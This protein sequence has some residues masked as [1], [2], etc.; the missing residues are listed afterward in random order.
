[1]TPKVS[2]A[3]W[4]EEGLIAKAQLYVEKMES[5]TAD[6]WQF[7]LWSTFVLELVARAA[8][9][10]ISPVLLA[11]AR[12]WRNLTYA[13]GHE[14][15]A[16][17][18][19]PGSIPTSEVVGRLEELVPEVTREISGICRQHL[20]RRNAELH[21]GELIF[22]KLGTSNWLPSFYLALQT[23]I[24]V[25]GKELQDIVSDP[26]SASSMIEAMQD[27]TAKA[28]AQDIE[29]HQKVWS[30]KSDEERNCYRTG[31]DLGNTTCRSSCQLSV[32]R[33]AGTPS[34]QPQWSGFNGS[35]SERNHPTANNATNI[36]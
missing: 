1:M 35:R 13:L 11:D 17:R 19:T 30:N 29:A 22:S 16:R 32:L 21:S 27:E 6:D 28:V 20:N 12:N 14:P 26:S 34:R 3:P 36:F 7:S 23:L 10:H 24:R 18:F 25:M 15:T 5:H 33:V 2:H 9:A 8:L 31:Q 4:S